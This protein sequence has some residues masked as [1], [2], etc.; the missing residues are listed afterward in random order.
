MA[1]ILGDAR[2]RFLKP[3][4]RVL[5][6]GASVQ[7]ALFEDEKAYRELLDPLG[8][9]TARLYGLDL[10]PLREIVLN[11]LSYQ[12]LA[13][14]CV[15]S[16]IST[17]HRCDLRRQSPEPFSSRHTFTAS[18]SGMAHGLAVWFDL[19]LGDGVELS[20]GPGTPV[21][22]W[23]QGILPFEQPL[24]LISGDPIEVEVRTVV[25]RFYGCYWNWTVRYAPRQAQRPI[26][27]RQ[28]TF[29]GQPLPQALA[30]YLCLAGQS[31]RDGQEEGA[32][33]N[34]ASVTA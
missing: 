6:R 4:G 3:G 5:P 34:P 11:A 26:L 19:D 24:S 17:V 23:Q 25:S 15:L 33:R 7:V 12:G 8:D 9:E 21:T 29:R 32:A 28:T 14:G 1:R 16:D 27:L 20:N 22:S 31:R 30:R 2:G 13:P 18:R 10:A